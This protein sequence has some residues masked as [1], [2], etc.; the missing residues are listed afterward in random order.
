MKKKNI[1][2]IILAVVIA[3]AAVISAI[4]I[5][6]YN[7]NRN[8]FLNG[9]GNKQKYIVDAD[10]QALTNA[11]GKYAVVITDKDGKTPTYPDKTP[12]TE[13]VEPA[14]ASVGGNIFETVDIKITLPKEFKNYRALGQ[15]DGNDFKSDKYS[16]IIR[17]YKNSTADAA[18][19]LYLKSA[20]NSPEERGAMDIGRKVRIFDSSFNE[21]TLSSADGKT[22]TIPAHKMSVYFFEHKDKAYSVLFIGKEMDKEYTDKIISSVEFK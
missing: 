12:A 4:F 14:A 9:D 7:K 13:F 2:I 15:E 20:Q 3:L 22:D 19:N 16:V 18:V 8:T 5:V 1:A 11:D 21:E 6:R 10:G 17:S